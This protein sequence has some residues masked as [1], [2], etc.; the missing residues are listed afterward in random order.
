MTY[1]CGTTTP[2]IRLVVDFAAPS[3]QYSWVAPRR[4]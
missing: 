1:A 3:Q 4:G 2:A